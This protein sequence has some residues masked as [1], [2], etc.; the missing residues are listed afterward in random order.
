L[1]HQNEKN[2]CIAITPGEPAGIGPE[3]TLKLANQSLDYEIVAVASL[4]MLQAQA[5]LLGLRID[6]KSFNPQSEYGAH[7]AGTLK[8]IN[9][10][11]SE[12]AVAEI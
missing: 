3:L 7:T 4:E 6:F 5:E 10:D 8:V 2:I 1:A 11:L 12:P 9:I